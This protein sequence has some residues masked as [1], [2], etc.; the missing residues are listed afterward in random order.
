[1]NIT[2]ISFLFQITL[3]RVFLKN[4]NSKLKSL[5][6]KIINMNIE[7][8]QESAEIIS[9]PFEYFDAQ[10]IFAKKIS[11]ITEDSLEECMLNYTDL[12][13]SITNKE[14]G[15]EEVK[16]NFSPLWIEYTEKIK[17]SSD[18]E[19]IS[20][21]TYNLFL[22]QKHSKI[23]ISEGKE[24]EKN[25]FGCFSMNYGDYNKER[26]QIKLHF[27]PSRKDLLKNDYET[28]Y[29]DLSS[30]YLPQR[31]QEFREMVKYIHD[32]PKLFEGAKHLK[33]STWLQ[34]RPN[35]QALFPRKYSSD[36]NRI[37]KKNNFLGLWG[38]FVKWDLN[39]NTEVFKKFK[40]NLEKA[41]TLENAINSFPYPV[42]EIK[43]PLE[44][45]FEMY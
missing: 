4:A 12:Y 23:K 24:K 44:E 8:E 9:Q 22:K 32:N 38:Q 36:G 29:G 41:Q 28:K 17:I 7:T 5:Y 21:I 10:I 14:Y 45:L 6:V 11:D 42:Y 18:L 16:G 43:V 40:N 2:I 27:T 26:K 35:Y 31:K 30:F 19:E 13:N 34:N 37:R 20:N 39:G 33:S 25:S 15:N 3:N 1:M